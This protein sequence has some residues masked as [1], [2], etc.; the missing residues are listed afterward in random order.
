MRREKQNKKGKNM[1]NIVSKY[2][3]IIYCFYTIF[4]CFPSIFFVCMA[5]CSESKVQCISFSFFIIH[6]L[7]SS[8]C[9]LSHTFYLIKKN[10]IRRSKTKMKLYLREREKRFK[11][12]KVNFGFHL[13]AVVCCEKAAHT[14]FHGERTCVLQLLLLLM[15]L[16]INNN[17][18]HIFVSLLF[19]NCFFRLLCFYGA[20]FAHISSV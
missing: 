7:I 15:L 18:L 19:L 9:S 13:I 5:L 3:I 1:Y 8:L 16:Q 6:I 12:G 20:R 2:N 11:H 17:S 4:Y 10:L 14:L